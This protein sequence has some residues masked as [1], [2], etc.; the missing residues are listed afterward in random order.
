M[1]W[2]R[3][4]GQWKQFKSRAQQ[5][6][7]RITDD[8]WEFIAGKRGKLIGRVQSLYGK[9]KDQAERDVDNWTRGINRTVEPGQTR[10]TADLSWPG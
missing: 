1:N 6:W 9:K 2:N 8:D 10:Q 7:A 3:I 4:E 5:R